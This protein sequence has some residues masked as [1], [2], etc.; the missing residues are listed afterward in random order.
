MNNKPI[1]FVI[2]CIFLGDT[3][4]G[5]TTLLRKITEKNFSYNFTPTI[6]VDFFTMFDSL[7][8][9]NYKIDFWDTAGHDNFQN[10]VKTYYKNNAICYVVYDVC[11]IVSFTHVTK[12]I[13]AFKNNTSNSNAILVILANKIDESIKRVV[14]YEEGIKMANIY[15][16]IYI[17]VSSKTSI[18]INKIVVE[19]MTQLFYLLERNMIEMTDSNGIRNIKNEKKYK[20]ETKKCCSLQ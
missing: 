8:N 9:Y 18:G 19:P 14:T 3:G 20:E 2:K 5:K 17:E 10:L 16:A 1:N 6:G 4:V 13:S 12:W 7:K 15:N 11:N